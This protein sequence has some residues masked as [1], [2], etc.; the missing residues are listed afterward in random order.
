MRTGVVA[1]KVG[2]TRVFSET[3]EHVPVTSTFWPVTKCAP[4][5]TVPGATSASASTRNSVT[6]IGASTPAFAKWPRSA[7][8]TPF[9]LRMPAPSC[10][11]T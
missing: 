11:A 10:R 3:G 1:K 2:M 7:L 8:L 6:F 9:G 4:L 5:S